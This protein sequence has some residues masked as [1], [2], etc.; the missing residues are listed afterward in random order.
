MRD[1]FVYD[2]MLIEEDNVPPDV[3]VRL[4]KLTAELGKI[5]AKEGEGTATATT[6]QMSADDARKWL[7]EIV[8]M[9]EG[10]CTEFAKQDGR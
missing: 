10:T 6:S 9:Y 4:Q 1:A 3:W 8:S 5:P 2:L 7:K